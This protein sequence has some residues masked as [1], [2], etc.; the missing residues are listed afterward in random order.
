MSG[1][2]K[3]KRTKLRWIDVMRKKHEEERSK[4]RRSTRPENV[5]IEKSMRRPQIWE[6]AEEELW[7]IC[8]LTTDYLRITC[9]L[10]GAMTAMS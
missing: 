8:G 9:K 7:I 4:D 5:G 6:K 3:I 10:Y 1:H 2:R